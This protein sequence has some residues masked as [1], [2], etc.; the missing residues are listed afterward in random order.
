MSRTYNALNKRGSLLKMA[1]KIL[2]IALSP[3]ME[4]GVITKWNKKAGDKISTG[5]LLCEV[6]TDKASMD[7]ES[8]DDGTLLKILVP[9]GTQV[10]VGDPIAIMGDEGEDFSGLL[11][12]LTKKSGFDDKKNSP[13]EN[14]DKT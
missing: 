9:N 5:D 11:S 14:K 2:M 1:E 13:S 10:K 8:Q 12:S 6:E 3:T 4:A 7:Y